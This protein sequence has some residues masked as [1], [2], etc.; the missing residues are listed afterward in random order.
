MYIILFKIKVKEIKVNNFS[1]VMYL[2][3]LT[4]GINIIY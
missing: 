4:E 2:Y 3:T 1:V